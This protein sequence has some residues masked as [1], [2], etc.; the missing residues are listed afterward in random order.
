MSA[1][2]VSVGVAVADILDAP[3]GR[4]TRQK[5]AGE[6]VTILADAGDAVQVR[7]SDGYEGFVARTSLAPPVVVTHA[8][9]A[10]ATHCYPAPDLK[11]M[12]TH[13]LS[14]PFGARVRV[15]DERKAFFET[16][17]GFIPKP[18]LRPL[19]QPYKDPVTVAQLHFNVPYLWGGNSTRGIDCSGL[20]Q[21][22]L[23]ACEIPCPGDSGMQRGA[24]GTALGDDAPLQRG[25]LI[26]WPGHVGMMVD[27]ETMI[28]ANA[29]HMA[30]AY[31]PVDKAI[32]RIAA[33]GGGEVLA[34]RRTG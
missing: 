2:E 10:F 29:H 26:F 9:S 13:V 1:A 34:R 33:Q 24:V 5:R 14:L 30:V 17:W 21:A 11:S 22:A 12:G 7:A 20:V 18:H 25:D 6:A 16:D 4:R 27:A 28:H 23:H 31:E 3:D 19:S 32:R 8:V 15:T